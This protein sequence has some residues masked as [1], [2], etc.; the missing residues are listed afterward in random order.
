MDGARFAAATDELGKRLVASGYGVPGGEVGA[1]IRATIDGLRS[2]LT[3]AAMPKA[4]AKTKERVGS[5]ALA[6]SNIDVRAERFGYPAIPSDEPK[7]GRK[8]RRGVRPSPHPSRPE[9]GAVPPAAPPGSPTP[10]EASEDR[11]P[12]P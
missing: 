3:Q 2:L 6:C 5:V 7:D 10:S 11:N 1:R 4:D 8:R 12:R 9:N